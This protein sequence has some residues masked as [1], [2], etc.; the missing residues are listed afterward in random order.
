MYTA[1]VHPLL[2]ETVWFEHRQMGAQ[3]RMGAVRRW[4]LT[5]LYNKRLRR[6]EYLWRLVSTR[7]RYLI[8]KRR[9]VHWEQWTCRHDEAMLLAKTVCVEVNL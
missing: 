9:G 2:D 7:E 5:P 4:I 3:M 8:G 1:D 6:L